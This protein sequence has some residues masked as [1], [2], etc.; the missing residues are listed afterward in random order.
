MMRIKEYNRVVHRKLTKF[1]WDNVIAIVGNEG[2]SKST[3]GLHI[4]Q[5]W[6]ELL[7]GCCVETDIKHICLDREQFL[8]DLGD[9]KRYEITV[10]DEAGDLNSRRAMSHFNTSIMKAYQIIRAD[11]LFTILVL[12]SLWELDSFFRLRRLRGFYYV[13]ARGRCAFWGQNRMKK[14]LQL[15]ANRLIKNYFAVKPTF[16]D[17]FP[18]YRG[19]MA[20]GYDKKKQAKTLEVRKN[21]LGEGDERENPFQIK[22]DRAVVNLKNDTKDSDYVGRIFEISKRQVNSIV[23]KVA[24]QGRVKHISM[25]GR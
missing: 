12:P 15:N 4:T 24:E 13:F 22:R 17:T 20:E 23:Q 14:M 5:D 8:K 19:V 18:I 25:G 21:L 2:V 11:N 6:Y 1:K 10:Y 7:N 3:L 16:Y 9:L